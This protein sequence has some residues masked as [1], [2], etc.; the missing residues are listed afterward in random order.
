M[1]SQRLPRIPEDVPLRLPNCGLVAVCVLTGKP[2]WEVYNTVAD[3][4]GKNGNWK[5]SSWP[6]QLDYVLDLCGTKRSQETWPEEKTLMAFFRDA[7]FVR[8]ATYMI[9]VTGHV[10]VVHRGRIY[11]QN[12]PEGDLILENRFRRS[13]IHR[14]MRFEQSAINGPAL[15]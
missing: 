6:H 9:H 14:V 15:D 1:T 3:R 11:D 7:R 2:Y 5:G 13:R 10:I 12:T 4:Y 8:S